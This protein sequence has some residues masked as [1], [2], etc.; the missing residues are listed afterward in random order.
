[1]G[2]GQNQSTLRQGDIILFA[3]QSFRAR[4]VNFFQSFFAKSG[5]SI[6]NH[7][8]LVTS[9]DGDILHAT[10]WR[11]KYTSLKRRYRRSQVLVV[12]W[13]HLTLERFRLGMAQVGPMLGRPFAFWRQVLHAIRLGWLFSGE[14]V[15]CS[16]LVAKFLS[17]AGAR[18]G[19]W[20]GVN[21]NDL[22]EEFMDNPSHYQVVFR[23]RLMDF[24]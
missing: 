19:H 10:R 24:F 23:G 6:Y 21:V 17:A 9:G 13:R 11:I 5:V 22:Y 14:Y 20:A 3:G 2:E 4:L 18:P 16:E 1:V 8:A 7:A 12:R 15:V